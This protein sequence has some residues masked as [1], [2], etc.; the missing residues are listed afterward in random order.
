MFSH[1]RLPPGS[2]VPGILEARILEWVVMPSS[3]G[4]FSLGIELASPSTP[5][6]AGGFFIT[7]PPGKPIGVY[8]SPKPKHLGVFCSHDPITAPPLSTGPA[9]LLQSKSPLPLS[10][11]DPLPGPALNIIPFLTNPRG[12][13]HRG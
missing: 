2:S 12:T 4:S 8:N 3:R 9:S 5:A 13:W 11:Q 10:L 6:L 1:V 7:E